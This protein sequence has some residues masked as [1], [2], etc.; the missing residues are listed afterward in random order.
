[1]IIIIIIILKIIK[2]RIQYLY[3]S[4]ICMLIEM[5]TNVNK[6]CL[7]H[8]PDLIPPIAHEGRNQD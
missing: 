6:L 7:N 3:F 4:K 5:K 8:N 2:K 1:M